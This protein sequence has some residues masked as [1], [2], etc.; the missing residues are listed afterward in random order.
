MSSV[1]GKSWLLHIHNCLP[2]VKV[3]MKVCPVVI[4][5]SLLFSR[6][7]NSAKM[8][9][10][11]Q[12]FQTK[13]SLL[14]NSLKPTTV[15]CLFIQI[16]HYH[17]PTHH[18]KKSYYLNC[19]LFCEF[20]ENARIIIVVRAFCFIFFCPLLVLIVPSIRAS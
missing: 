12:K 5:S 18:Q 11:N 2:Q 6:W 10:F 4:V 3:R 7:G 14:T 16:F 15:F 1:I 17:S 13:H 20:V 19:F 8:G 9:S